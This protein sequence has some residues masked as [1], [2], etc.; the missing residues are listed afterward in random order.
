VGA[1]ARRS[2]RATPSRAE[3]SRRRALWYISDSDAPPP[4]NSIAATVGFVGIAEEDV[5]SFVFSF[6]TPTCSFCFFFQFRKNGN[7]KTVRWDRRGAVTWKIGTGRL[8]AFGRW[9]SGRYLTPVGIRL[10]RYG[11]RD[12]LLSVGST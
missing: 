9:H 12:D 10:D 5:S 2:T 4:E 11:Y 6:P 7:S 8:I 3:S 1:E